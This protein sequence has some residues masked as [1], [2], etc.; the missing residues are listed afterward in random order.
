ML[1]K[2]IQ[3]WRAKYPLSSPQWQ[4]SPTGSE[5]SHKLK[6]ETQQEE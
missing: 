5:F 3:M 6:G 4:T 2:V 1:V